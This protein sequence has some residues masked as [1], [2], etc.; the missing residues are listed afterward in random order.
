M[1]LRKGDQI[2]GMD[3]VISGKAGATEQLMTVMANG[4]GKRTKLSEDKSQG[5][6]GS[7]VKTAQIT[8]KTGPI[9]AAMIV[10]GKFVGMDKMTESLAS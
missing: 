3:L 2:V 10:D 5:R 6:G 9:S 8:T 1:R 7:G 4:F